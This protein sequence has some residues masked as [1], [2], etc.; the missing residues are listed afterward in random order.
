MVA[1]AASRDMGMVSGKGRRE[2]DDPGGSPD[3]ECVQLGM[4]KWLQLHAPDLGD[5]S[6]EPRPGCNDIY[7]WNSLYLQVHFV[8]KGDHI[9]CK[10]I[11]ECDLNLD[12]ALTIT[13]PIVENGS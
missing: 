10:A 6:G 4:G 13:A 7:V 3:R 8:W 12:S 9:E 11:V 2:G 1:L 5:S